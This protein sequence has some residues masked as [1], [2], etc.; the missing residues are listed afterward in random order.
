VEKFYVMA[1]ILVCFLFFFC[2]Q[3]I[4]HLIASSTSRPLLSRIIETCEALDGA[5]S[6]LFLTSNKLYAVRDPFGF[7]PLVVGRRP[8]GIILTHVCTILI[9]DS[10]FMLC[11]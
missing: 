2:N 6:L 1:N 11:Q 7:R 4:L 9:G 8:N 3:V 5:Y 10:R